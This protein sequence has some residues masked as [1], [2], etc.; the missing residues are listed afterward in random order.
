MTELKFV[1][2]REVWFVSAFVNA[3]EVDP[4]ARAVELA[5]ALQAEIRGVTRERLA[6]LAWD[7]SLQAVCLE[8]ARSVTIVG[9]WCT[10][11]DGFPYHDENTGL[12]YNK[13]GHLEFA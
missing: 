6:A 1:P 10:F 9:S 11:V 4:H 7:P 3:A 8:M 2:Q 13:L 5:A 12:A